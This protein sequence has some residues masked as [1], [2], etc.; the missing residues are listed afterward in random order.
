[1]NSQQRGGP[2]LIPLCVQMSESGDVGRRRAL[3]LGARQSRRSSIQ[4]PP[5]LGSQ[6][7]AGNWISIN[8]RKASWSRLFA[9]VLSAILIQFLSSGNGALAQDEFLPSYDTEIVIHKARQVLELKRNGSKI[10]EYRVCLGLNPNGPKRLTGDRRT[11]EGD[12]FICY[13]STESQFHRFLGIS[14]PGI[15]DAQTAFEQG[16]ISK[17]VRDGIIRSLENGQ[18]PPWD[19]KLGGWVGIHGYPSEEYRRRWIALFYPKPHNWTD[20]CIAMWNFEIEDLYA[21]VSVG[22]PVT[23]LP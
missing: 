3:S 7:L 10:K 19:T 22:T 23:I 13:K 4:E 15:Q 11:P 18:T 9:T 1:M 16:I 12:Y 17:D 14:Y 6:L 2:G 5:V 8:D 20:G 21:K